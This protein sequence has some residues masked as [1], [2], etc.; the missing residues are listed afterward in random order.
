MKI[1][2]R[3]YNLIEM[4]NETGEEDEKALADLGNGCFDHGDGG[5]SSFL[6][7]KK[8][9]GIVRGTDS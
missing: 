6:S 2:L 5:S 7:R 3:E 4:I 1:S 9:A 8:A